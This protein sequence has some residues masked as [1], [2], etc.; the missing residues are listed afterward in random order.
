MDSIGSGIFGSGKDSGNSLTKWKR[1]IRKGG[2]MGV[3]NS[4]TLKSGR[5]RKSSLKG[6][7]LPSNFPFKSYR[8]TR[9]HSQNENVSVEA[10]L[11]AHWRSETLKFELSRD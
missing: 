7:D 3:S 9:S 11:Q 8:K 4:S 6:S 10:V 1:H 2:R 5:K